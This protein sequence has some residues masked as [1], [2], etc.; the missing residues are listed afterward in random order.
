[1]RISLVRLFVS[2]REYVKRVELTPII[3]LSRSVSVVLVRVGR[4]DTGE[5]T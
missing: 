1:M 5:I 2:I 3:Q 4:A